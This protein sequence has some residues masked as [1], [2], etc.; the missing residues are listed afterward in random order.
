MLTSQSKDR[1]MAK[2]LVKYKGPDGQDMIVEE[3]SAAQERAEADGYK[4]T[5]AKVETPAGTE[6]EADA[7]A[8]LTEDEAEKAQEAN[9]GPDGTLEGKDKQG[10]GTATDAE[11]ADVEAG[12]ILDE[13]AG[14]PDGTT[15]GA[16]KSIGTTGTSGPRPKN[17]R[18]DK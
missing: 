18:R 13:K 10:V 12:R 4:K 2:K 14:N 5:T 6:A 3:G 15:S 16:T 1:T 7:R 8:L 11:P 9:P 17:A